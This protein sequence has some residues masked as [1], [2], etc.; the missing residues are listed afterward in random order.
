MTFFS[1]E[2]EESGVTGVL[3]K[4]IFEQEANIR[5]VDML[6]RCLSGA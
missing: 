2:I 1:E 3:E 6:G 5:G 4:Y